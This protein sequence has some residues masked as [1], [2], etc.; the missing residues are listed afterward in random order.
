MARYGIIILAAGSSSR[1][2]QP[3]QLLMLNGSTFIEHVVHQA[4][5]V[6]EAIPLVVSGA[7]DPEIQVA[8]A[9]FGTRIFFN[10]N[11]A[12]G[13]SRSIK[14]GIKA[15]LGMEPAVEACMLVVCDQPHVSTSLFKEMISSYE[16]AGTGILACSYGDTAGSPAIFGRQYFDELMCLEGQEGAKK[17]IKKY[18][19]NVSYLPFPKGIVDIDT[20]EDYVTFISGQQ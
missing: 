12:Q 17:I 14:T 16:Q 6:P 3:K 5:G 10:T 8:L 13:M 4:A 18:Q 11:W 1:L 2:G 15:L 19:T 20:A 9:G 7:A